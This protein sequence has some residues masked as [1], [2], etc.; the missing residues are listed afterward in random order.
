M[1]FISATN[2]KVINTMVGIYFHDMP[3]NW[4][5]PI[6]TMGL[7]RVPS[8]FTDSGTKTT[9]KNYSFH[10]VFFIVQILIALLR[11]YKF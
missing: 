8:F 11:Y 7:G 1:A 2:D 9:C 10:I 5:P 3:E 6:S 4:L